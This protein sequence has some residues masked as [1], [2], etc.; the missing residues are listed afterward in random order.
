MIIQL[1]PCIQRDG[2]VERCR[3]GQPAAFYGVYKGNLGAYQWVAD[4]A[5]QVEARSYASHLAALLDAK[6]EDNT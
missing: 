2:H 6:L 1:N 4:F 5:D 3:P